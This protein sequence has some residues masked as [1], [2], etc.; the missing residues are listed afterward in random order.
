MCV[1]VGGG[2]GEGKRKRERERERERMR[3]IGWEG[4]GEGERKATNDMYM[5]TLNDIRCMQRR[6]SFLD[7][8]TQH[9]PQNP[10]LRPLSCTL[11]PKVRSASWTCS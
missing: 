9:R 4:E 6:S 1:C 3:E 5:Y 10:R 7:R 8:F 11:T 2:G